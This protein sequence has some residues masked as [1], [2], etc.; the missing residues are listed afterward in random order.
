M[1]LPDAD[2]IGVREEKV[3]EEE[4]GVL[5]VLEPTACCH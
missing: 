2:A 4:E 5:L 3:V 1:N